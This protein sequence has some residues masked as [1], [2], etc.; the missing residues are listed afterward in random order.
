MSQGKLQTLRPETITLCHVGTVWWPGRLGNDDQRH[1][2]TYQEAHGCAR[3]RRRARALATRT[4]RR[5]E[6]L[7]A[8]P[9]KAGACSATA[10]WSSK[11]LASCCPTVTLLPRTDRLT[12]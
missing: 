10:L 7:S 8:T 2:H 11:T 4:T 6:P 3:I 12:W 1:P 9:N 5:H